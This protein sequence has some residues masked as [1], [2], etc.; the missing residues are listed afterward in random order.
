MHVSRNTLFLA[1]ALALALPLGV[2]AAGD[3]SA[4]TGPND[5]QELD[6]VQVTGVKQRLEQAGRLADTIEQTEVITADDLQRRQAGSLSQAVD[7]T[8]GIRVQN[9]CSMCGI[10]RVMINGLKGEH[11]TILVDG[12][13]MHSTVSSYYGIDA[14]TS[15]A[16]ESIEVARGP[17]AALATPEAI[18][19][20][21]NI[22]SKRATRDGAMIDLAA[23]EN[24]YVRSSAVG[25]LLSEDGRAEGV[26][27]A[28]YD[29]IDRFDG[30]DN[31]VSESAELSNRS[32]S[33]RG[34]FDPTERDNLDGRLALF[35][36]RVLGGPA[37]ASRREIFDSAASGLETDP[38]GF[39]EG[40]D[41]R[42]ISWHCPSR[43]PR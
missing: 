20:A 23:G 22:I 13:P 4:A 29:D 11:T 40:G 10:K 14:I 3:P 16:I 39:F 38:T 28:Q 19:G 34:S 8:P 15:A 6:T 2:G 43:P 36:S 5:A 42:Q 24:G 32:V 21:I 25:T 7:N 37:Q 41:V 26:F 31:G 35:R 30:D 33:A 12:V 17:G 1:L 18:G 27:A 9:E